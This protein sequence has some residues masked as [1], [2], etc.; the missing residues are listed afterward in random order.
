MI[1]TLNSLV[2][3]VEHIRSGIE[4]DKLKLADILESLIKEVSNLK[5]RVTNL[6]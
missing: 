5:T 1:S 6:E 2:I 3:M 4:I